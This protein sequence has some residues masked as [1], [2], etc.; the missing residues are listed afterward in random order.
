[1]EELIIKKNVVYDFDMNFLSKIQPQGGMVFDQKYIRKG[2]GYESCIFVYEYPSEVNEFWLYKLISMK[3]VISTLDV[4]SSE[5]SK[6]IQDINK[7]LLEQKMRYIYEKDHTSKVDAEEIHN[8][9]EK[10][11][12]DVSQNGEVIKYIRLR[13]FAY[14]MTITELETKT[15]NIIENLEG[16]GCKGTVLIN[17]CEFEWK[18]LFLDYK[19]QWNNDK[20]DGT[21]LPCE[22]L[23][24]G[25]PF[26]FAKLHDPLGTFYG[27]TDTGGNVIFD[28][29][30][31][32]AIR[33]HYNTVILGLMGAGKSSLL[34]KLLV[35]NA[36]RGNLVRGFDITGEFKDLIQ[37]LGGKYVSL[38]GTDGVINPLE[39]FKTSEDEYLCFSQHISKVSTF[40]QFLSNDLIDEDK[41]QFEIL[42]RQLY[43]KKGLVPEGGKVVTGLS[44]EEYPVFSDFLKLLQSKLYEDNDE[45]IIDSLS[46][47]KALR[48][49]RIELKIRNLI[50]NYGYLFNKHSSIKNILEE[51]ILFFSIRNLTSLKKEIFNAELFSALS[52]LWDDLLKKGKRQKDLFESGSI[53]WNDVERYMIIMDEATKI[54]NTSNLMAVEY[55]SN[56]AR[57]ARKYFGSIIFS[58]HS[59]RDCI[60]DGSTS[61]AVNM[62]TT[63][64]ELTQYKFILQQDSN[65]LDVLKNVFKYQLSDHELNLI[66]QLR[67]GQ[68]ILSIS[69]GN[70]IKFDIFLSEKEKALFK[71]GV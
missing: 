67:Q 5:R 23:G 70:N 6:D 52:L 22:T 17:E 19:S 64:F 55:I 56:F 14:A 21:G 46:K 20:R 51:K 28:L 57:E 27:V 50:D 33:K 63:L 13:I 34:K 42:L 62:I 47:S 54:I 38:D 1:M 44:P 37:A 9:L 18:S 8:S 43:Y 41:D 7:S 35:D 65:T 49:E 16:I 61:E 26:H 58:M 29:F 24:G 40:Y 68:C 71:G 31:K 66:P 32:D 25:Y 45:K 69:G 30:Y 53:D 59:I 12:R 48:F 2:D 36:T 11:Y 39:I 4:V 3:D 15:K 60:T 10:L